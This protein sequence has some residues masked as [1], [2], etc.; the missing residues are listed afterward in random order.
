MHTGKL[1]SKF[2]ATLVNSTK[3]QYYGTPNVGGTLEMTWNT[4]LVRAERVNI[5][6]WGYRETGEYTCIYSAY[7]H[8]AINCVKTL[9]SLKCFSVGKAYTSDWRGEWA[10][11]Y[12]LAKD[13][14]N[15]GTFSFLPKIAE[16]GFSSWELGSLR[17]SPS[18]YLDGMWYVQTLPII[19]MTVIEG[20]EIQSEK[21]ICTI[22][23][24]KSS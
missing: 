13:H 9:N 1:D 2:K 10:Y 17:V 15:N 12:S 6:L 16:N 14:P 4:S 7:T 18:T 11:L 21:L 3:W 8:I 24:Y 19:Y 5:E 22:N 20:K 23:E